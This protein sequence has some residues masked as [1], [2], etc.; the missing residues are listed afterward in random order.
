MVLESQDAFGA[1]LRD[2]FHGQPGLEIVERDDGFIG[3]GP[4][5]RYF[6]PFRRWPALQRRAMRFA[7]GSILDVGCG[8]GRVALHLQGRGLEVVAIDVSP[9]AVAVAHERGVRDVRLMALAELEP[10]SI[11]PFDTVCMFGNNLG[12]FESKDRAG[13]LFTRLAHVTTPRARIL[14]ESRDPYDTT[15]ERHRAYQEKNR[16]LGRMGGQVRLRVRYRHLA[17]EW[18]DW[19]FVSTDELEDLVRGTGW[20]VGRVLSDAGPE[21]MAVLDKE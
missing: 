3:A 18:F 12:L 13:P 7:R 21:Y 2:G 19:L 5:D 9:G 11:G 10:R 17:T 15:D 16:A 14:V 6:A 4:A 20:R 8:A 1:L